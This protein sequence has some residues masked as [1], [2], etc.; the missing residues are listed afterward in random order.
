MLERTQRKSPRPPDLLS[1]LKKIK[2]NLQ[3]QH[4]VIKSVLRS[5]LGEKNHIKNVLVS[6]ES[7]VGFLI[8]LN[9]KF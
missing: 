9:I 5:R 2:I 1:H 4:S 6:I 8:Q 3:F 7:L